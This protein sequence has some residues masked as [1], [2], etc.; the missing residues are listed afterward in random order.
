[1]EYLNLNYLEKTDLD[2]LMN[3]DNGYKKYVAQKILSQQSTTDGW[4]TPNKLLPVNRGENK[5]KLIIADIIKK[6]RVVVKISKKKELLEKDFLTSKK[7]EELNCVNFAKY[8]GFFSCKDDIDNYNLD[9]PLPKYFCKNNG[10]ENYFLFMNYYP[11]G[12]IV[13]Y[14]PKN[15]NEII[16]IINQVIASTTLAFEKLGFIHGDLHLGNVLIKNTKKDFI[17]YKYNDKDLEI[18]TNGIEI[19]MFDF[20]RSNFSGNFGIFLNEILAFI[21]FYDSYLLESN[22]LKINN[23]SITPL[24]T[25]KKELSKVINIESLKNIIGD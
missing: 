4:L 24:R 16:S 8:L 11:S 22:L 17:K 2:G 18:K 12:S 25:L 7:L 10:T 15:I 14:K 19:V 20:D 23:I 9:K 1:M 13:N 21:N 5:N 3:N 6:K